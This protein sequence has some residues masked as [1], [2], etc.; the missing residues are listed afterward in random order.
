MGEILKRASANNESG[1]ESWKCHGKLSHYDIFANLSFCLLLCKG[2]ITQTIFTLNEDEHKHKL[3]W[4]HSSVSHVDCLTAF[5]YYSSNP[6]TSCIHW[7]L[8]SYFP[9]FS[10]GSV[11]QSDWL[12][13]TFCLTRTWKNELIF[14]T[15]YSD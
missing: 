14:N 4:D 10:N 6:T 9:L 3:A 12:Q 13:I 11:S 7:K 5:C 15:W 1:Y 2:S 8:K